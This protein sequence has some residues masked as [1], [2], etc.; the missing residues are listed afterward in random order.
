M[1]KKMLG[2]DIGSSLLKAVAL[3]RDL[4]GRLSVAASVL[5]DV[6]A[7]GGPELALRKLFAD[8]RFKDGNSA[9]SIPAGYCSFRNLALPFSES[10][11]IDEIITYELEPH[12]P[13]PIETVVVDHL[14]IRS[15]TDST[16]VLAAAARKPDIDKLTQYASDGGSDIAVIDTD[17]VPIALNI[18]DNE[19]SDSSWILLDIGAYVSVA[20]FVH[21][22]S[23]IHIRSFSWGAA[24]FTAAS[25]NVPDSLQNEEPEK[26]M[27]ERGGS[28]KSKKAERNLQECLKEI[29]DT[30]QFL[31]AQGL[32]EEPPSRIYLT[33]GG[34]L[35]DPLRQELG[36]FFK[37]PTV[38]VDL[39]KMKGIVLQG[40]NQLSWNAPLMNQAL[41]LALRGVDGSRGFNFRKGEIVSAKKPQGLMSHL[42]WTAIILAILLLCLGTNLIAGY[43]ADSRKLNY[44]KAE[45]TKSFK[46]SC[47]EITRI[48]DP[49]RQLQQKISE[50]KNFSSG[51]EDGPLFLEH[52]K[53][54]MDTL[55]ENS[56][57]LI[58]EVNYNQT[59]L[60]IFGEAS[61]YQAI[62]QWKSELEKT[63]FFSDVQMQF[64]SATNKDAKNTFRLRMTTTHAL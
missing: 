17:A 10:K 9:F 33:G 25:Q 20:L 44:L 40:K 30:R 60:E 6:E 50:T 4:K 15:S 35:S 1:N 8:K 16:V 57:I 31:A 11:T 26:T 12:I 54:A 47:P 5:I 13:H 63:R 32:L 37:L 3:S 53:R 64:G 23:I 2:I 55:P 27:T 46:S 14:P 51:I 56:G 38:V 58:K 41:A 61:E 29:A 34:A 36:T 42:R 45:I 21:E 18:L 43:Y 39:I 59:S 24:N 49:V 52:W 22:N 19:T 7:A 28:Q 62:N 48:V